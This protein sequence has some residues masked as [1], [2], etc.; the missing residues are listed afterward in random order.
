MSIARM[1]RYRGGVAT[2]LVIADALVRS[3]DCAGGDGFVVR[4]NGEWAMVFSRMDRGVVSGHGGSF[5]G[6]EWDGGPVK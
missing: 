5:A 2:Q 1:I 4:W 3:R 6:S